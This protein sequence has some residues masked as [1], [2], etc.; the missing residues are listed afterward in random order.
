MCKGPKIRSSLGFYWTEVR[1][2]GGRAAMGVRAEVLVGRGGD[3]VFVMRVAGASG[4]LEAGLGS[5]ECC[6]E[7]RYQGSNPSPTAF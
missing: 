6:R 2:C 5:S 3:W 1:L 7:R 4:D